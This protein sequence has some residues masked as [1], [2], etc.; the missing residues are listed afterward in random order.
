MFKQILGLIFVFVLIS[1]MAQAAIRVFKPGQAHLTT[2]FSFYKSTKNF[3]SEG[4]EIESLTNGQY[5]QNINFT[6]RIDWNLTRRWNVFASASLVN[7]TSDNLSFKRTRTGFSDA[8]LGAQYWIQFQKL[9]LIPEASL[10]I[11]ITGFE[12][13][14]DEVFLSDG[15]LKA[16][17]GA[18]LQTQ[19]GSWIPL[20]KGFYEYRSEDLSHRFHYFTQITKIFPRTLKLSGHVGGYMSVFDDGYTDNASFR[21]N[22]NSRVNGSSFAHHGVNPQKLYAGGWLGFYASSNS[23]FSLGY[24]ADLNGKNASKND[25]ILL[26]WE[27][28]QIAKPKTISRKKKRERSFQPVDPNEDDSTPSDIFDKVEQEIEGE[29]Q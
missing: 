14:T 11:P 1:P 3:S 25:T 2:D 10:V 26:R 12:A 13:T 27:W 5:Y 9:V 28:L 24:Q 22:Y 19:W 7:A 15:V 4:G 23:I 8:V 20:I 29:D 17:L 6:P 18:N 21:N 16:N